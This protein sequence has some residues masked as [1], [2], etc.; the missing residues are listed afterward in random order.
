MIYAIEIASCDMIYISSFMKY[1]KEIRCYSCYSWQQP[2]HLSDQNVH[3]R[4]AAS[5][6]FTAVAQNV[7]WYSRKDIT[8]YQVTSVILI[9]NS[10]EYIEHTI[11]VKAQEVSYQVS[12]QIL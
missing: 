4:N 2:S 6:T 3:R 10:H 8:V 7:V 12:L 9:L 1:T 11:I 5:V